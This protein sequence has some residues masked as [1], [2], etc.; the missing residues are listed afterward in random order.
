MTVYSHTHFHSTNQSQAN[1]Q[2]DH[3]EP[4]DLRTNRGYDLVTA[5]EGAAGVDRPELLKVSS[6]GGDGELTA[7]H[8][9]DTVAT[10]YRYDDSGLDTTH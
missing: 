6:L 4:E 7:H 3:I 9:D 5:L 2:F 8:Y 1:A 10:A